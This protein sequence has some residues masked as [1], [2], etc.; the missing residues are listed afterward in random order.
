MYIYKYKSSESSGERE[1]KE[2]GVRSM[3]RRA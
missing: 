1:I 2:V 3:S